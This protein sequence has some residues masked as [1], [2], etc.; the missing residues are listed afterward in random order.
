M[1][2]KSVKKVLSGLLLGSFVLV[3]SSIP[4]IANTPAVNTED[5][6][7]ICLNS[8][9]LSSSVAP[10]IKNGKTMVPVRI[11]SEGIG[12][13][14]SW[15]DKSRTV[16]VEKGRST[17]INLRI[18]DKQARINNDEGQREVALAAEPFIKDNRTMVPV[19]FIAESLG[20]T[21]N[22]NEA[23]RTVYLQNDD[24]DNPLVGNSNIENYSI[25]NNTAKKTDLLFSFAD[26]IQEPQLRIL[27]KDE[28]VFKG[29]TKVK[30]DSLGDYR[31]ELLFSDTALTPAL[32]EKL[33][34]ETT[35]IEDNNLVQAIRLAYPPDDSAMVIYLGCKAYPRVENFTNARNLIFNLVAEDIQ[36]GLTVSSKKVE[37]KT[38][39]LEVN[40]SIP[41]ID[42][43]KDKKIQDK[44][45]NRFEK[46]AIDFRDLVAEGL[47]EYVAD[48]TKNGWPVH[49][50]Q[51]YTNYRVN[52]SK[53]DILSLYVEYYQYTG[54]AHGMTNRVC[55]TI[56]LKT[57]EELPLHDLFKSNINYTAVINKEI[58]KQMQIEPDKYF[59][60][61]LK[62][63]NGI[64]NEQEFYI[65]DGNLVICFGL[66]EI[67]PYCNGI[68]EFK[69]PLSLFGNK[70]NTEFLEKA[71]ALAMKY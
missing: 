45:N 19:R 38:E 30:D 35:T 43:L 16:T 42:G 6:I 17:E 52:Y 8:N 55:S 64:S 23:E 51:A 26:T 48:A 39:T 40:F 15:N 49:T 71:Q 62:N 3:N 25:F 12:A 34:L 68:I 22:W 60:D 4:V 32:R 28:L 53:N 50:Y 20:I 41:V 59:D 9:Y 57:G 58:K 47:D 33:S 10:I 54:G 24:T 31:V 36:E 63:W 27:A 14:V 5:T 44:I 61:T 69:V 67:A 29:E 65:E 66:Y 13:N 70:V 46:S 18:G 21:V 11:L 2:K 37:S 7:K 1:N 56:D